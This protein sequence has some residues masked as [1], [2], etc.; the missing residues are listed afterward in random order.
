MAFR[1]INAP[2]TFQSYINKILI[3]KLNVFNDIFISTENKRE[4]YVEAVWWVIE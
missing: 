1:L 2:V 4:E 3:E